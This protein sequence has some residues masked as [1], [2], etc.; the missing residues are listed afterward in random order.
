MPIFL[1]S[2]H[3]SEVPPDRIRDFLRGAISATADGRGVRPLDLYCAD[4]GRVFYVVAAPDED[5]V[6]QHHAAQGVICRRV[7]HVQSLCSASQVLSE[8]DKAVVRGMIAAEQALSTA[9][10]GWSG[11]DDR[12][13]QVG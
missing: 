10:P 6:R 8:Q 2:H 4:D 13:S 3:G 12:L 9:T 11:P 5:T 7:R 1:D